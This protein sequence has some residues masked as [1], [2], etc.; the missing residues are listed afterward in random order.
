LTKPQFERSHWTS[1]TY[2]DC[3]ERRKFSWCG[4]GEDIEENKV[5]WGANQ[6]PIE[7]TGTCLSLVLAQGKAPYIEAV[8]CNKK[9]SYI[10]EVSIVLKVEIKN[11]YASRQ[12]DD[13]KGQSYAMAKNDMCQKTFNVSERKF[14]MFIETIR[15][16]YKM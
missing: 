4:I 9:I 15:I 7:K 2:L 3:E 12:D 14:N 13:T 1:G 10:C 8:D 11:K 16:W 5:T 6:P